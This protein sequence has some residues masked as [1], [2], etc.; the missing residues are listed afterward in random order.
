MAQVQNALREIGEEIE[1]IG[2]EVDSLEHI[3]KPLKD[4]IVASK[5]IDGERFNVAM[6]MRALNNG[7]RDFYA[8]AR[9]IVDAFREESETEYHWSDNIVSVSGIGGASAMCKFC[10]NE[11]SVPAL[12]HPDHSGVAGEDIGVY[13]RSIIDLYLLGKVKQ[14]RCECPAR[15]VNLRDTTQK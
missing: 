1:K 8:D 9:K 2:F 12:E 7:T 5:E 15:T 6:D 3:S 13:R 14:E 10:R 4:T 11:L